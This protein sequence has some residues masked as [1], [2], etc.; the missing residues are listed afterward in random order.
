MGAS[1]AGATTAAWM[2]LHCAAR[3][4]SVEIIRMLLDAGAE[5]D[6]TVEAEPEIAFLFGSDTALCLAAV[7]GQLGA[8]HEL[9]AAGADLEARD[10]RAGANPL[11]AAASGGHV[12]VV[13]ALAGYGADISARDEHEGWSCLHHFMAWCCTAE[14]SQLG[15]AP[16]KLRRLLEAGAD[17]ALASETWPTPLHLLILELHWHWSRQERM[18]E[19]NNR[20]PSPHHAELAR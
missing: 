20:N 8:V 2:P 10:C 19:A 14:G 3:G 5:V 18:E 1:A 9:V 4:G 6:A 17:V 16:G 7:A 12:D 15:A 11:L 13:C